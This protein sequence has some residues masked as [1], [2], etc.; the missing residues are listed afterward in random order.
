V[1][2]RHFRELEVYKPA[3]ELAIEIYEL[4]KSFP[5]EERYAL[6]GRIRRCSRSACANIGE[7]WR[8]RRYPAAFVAKISDPEA[9]AAETRVWLDFAPAHGYITRKT[10]SH[11]D[12]RYEHV[13]AMLVRMS[14]SPAQWTIKSTTR[15]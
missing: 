4:S 1:N 12:E 14:S 2:I 7:G 10:F 15:T 3:R 13:L 11:I 5:V 9:E 6:T 8:K